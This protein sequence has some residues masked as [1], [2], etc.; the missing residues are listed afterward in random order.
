MP[1]IYTI[2]FC[3]IIEWAAT[4]AL[5]WWRSH[6][7]VQ[8][9]RYRIGND[10]I[11]WSMCVLESVILIMTSHPLYSLWHGTLY[12]FPLYSLLVYGPLFGCIELVVLID[13]SAYC[14]KLAAVLMISVDFLNSSLFNRFMSVIDAY[15]SSTSF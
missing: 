4:V 10:Y 5:D 7:S 3:F 14:F 1:Y 9:I 2:F 6:K 12:W 11:E 13:F 8:V 15:K